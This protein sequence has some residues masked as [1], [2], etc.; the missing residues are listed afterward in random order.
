MLKFV[1]ALRAFTA[2]NSG[3]CS[4]TGAANGN[5]GCF[6]IAISCLEIDNVGIYLQEA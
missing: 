5:L 4:G 1:S 2:G 3:E 6:K